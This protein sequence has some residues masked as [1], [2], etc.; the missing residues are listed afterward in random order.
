MNVDD[1]NH[2]D[3]SLYAGVGFYLS[4]GHKLS[5]SVA[6]EVEVRVELDPRQPEASLLIAWI[7]FD[8]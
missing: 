8:S 1:N 7:Q 2:D 5:K 3:A 6:R 4:D